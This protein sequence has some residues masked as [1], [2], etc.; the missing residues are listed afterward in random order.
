MAYAIVTHFPGGTKAQYQ[1][2]L[3]AVHP[4]KTTLPTGQLFHVAGPSN[5]G[6]TV[7]AI[8]ESKQ[9]WEHFRDKIL[10]PKLKAGIPGGFSGP[11][12]E[13]SFEVENSITSTVAGAVAGLGPSATTP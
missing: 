13:T 5:G 2:S 8:H 12:T 10:L 11:P 7:M 3:A 4:S 9:S 6:Y 1:A